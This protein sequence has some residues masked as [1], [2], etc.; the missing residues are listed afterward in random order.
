DGIIV[1]T[2]VYY[3]SMASELKKLFDDSV[4]LHGKL[5]GKIGGAFSTSVN[6]GGGN[7]TAIMDIL[8]CMLIH[9]MVIQGV[10]K[11]DHYGPVAIGAPGERSSEQCIKYGQRIARLV[12]LILSNK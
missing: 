4:K 8:K 12:K 7:E 1:G 10:A 9:G 11:G 2:P 6:I 3:G 5:E